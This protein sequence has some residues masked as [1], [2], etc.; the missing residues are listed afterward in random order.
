MGSVCGDSWIG[1][2]FKDGLGIELNYSIV[3]NVFS[4]LSL[5]MVIRITQIF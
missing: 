3:E 1:K 2:F 4:P 5:Q